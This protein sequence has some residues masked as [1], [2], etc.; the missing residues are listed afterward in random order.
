M[1]DYVSQKATKKGGLSICLFHCVFN[2]FESLTHF[3]T[4]HPQE[5]YDLLPNIYAVCIADNSDGQKKI[6]A[7]FVIK[8]SY[9]ADDEDFLGS[10]QNTLSLYPELRSATDGK[11]C[12]YLPAKIGL[13]DS[14]PLSE[15]E[16]IRLMLQ[17]QLKYTPINN[18]KA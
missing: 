9:V 4:T 3:T 10:L 2:G 6:V 14:K 11:D 17:Q 15:D 7:G 1:T 13:S 16:L 8:T 18:M 12:S 5:L